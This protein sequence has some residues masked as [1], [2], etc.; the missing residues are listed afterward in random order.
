MADRLSVTSVVSIIGIGIACLPVFVM[1]SPAIELS[2]SES[3]RSH[4]FN[5]AQ[6]LRQT[7]ANPENSESVTTLPALDPWGQPYRLILLDGHQVRVL[8]SGPNMSFSPSGIDNDDIHSDMLVSPFD[9]IIAR[10]RLQLL[11][12]MAASVGCWVSL[13]ALY[14]WWQR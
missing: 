10:A 11:F 14:L 6:R 12:A 7:L 1:L 13:T 3:R 4:A 9:A 2:R 8:S 5:E